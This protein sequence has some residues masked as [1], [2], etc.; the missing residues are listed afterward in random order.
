MRPKLYDVVRLKNGHE[1][2]I[3]LIHGENEA[4]EVT[5]QDNVFSIEPEQIDEVI[6]HSMNLFKYVGK[7]VKITCDDE[8][9]YA[10]VINY[11]SAEDNE[12][13]DNGNYGGEA[14]T[15]IALKDT[16]YMSMGS[17]F[18]VFLYEIK[19]IEVI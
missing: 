18:E 8:Y 4:F 13:D 16:K 3:V 10:K 11:T 9:I 2:T 19:S 5:D 12:P 17:E 14:I 7:K 15:V 1:V 6:W